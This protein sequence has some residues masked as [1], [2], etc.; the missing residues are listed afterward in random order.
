MKLSAKMMW[1]WRSQAPNEATTNKTPFS[2][3]IPDSLLQ[4]IEQFVKFISF[5]F[6]APIVMR[7]TANI[8]NKQNGEIC[9]K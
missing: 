6:E 8:V 5:P 1:Q 3:F 4:T 9:S 7:R 2:F